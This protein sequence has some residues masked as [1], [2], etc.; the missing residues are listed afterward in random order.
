MVENQ[1]AFT[2]ITQSVAM[3]VTANAWKIKPGAASFA[4]VWRGLH[5][6][7]FVFFIRPAVE[8]TRRRT[9]S[10]SDKQTRG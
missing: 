2:D 3:K 6:T 1:S 4:I 8:E 5:A 9:T 7:L 10:R